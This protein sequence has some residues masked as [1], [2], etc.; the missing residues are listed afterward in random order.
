MLLVSWLVGYLVNQ[1]REERR[2]EELKS[3]WLTVLTNFHLA[4]DNLYLKLTTSI[5]WST[6]KPGKQVTISTF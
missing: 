3:G 5:N 2:K 6:A 1:L 4:T